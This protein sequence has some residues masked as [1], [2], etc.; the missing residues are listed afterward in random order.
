V[1]SRVAALI[2]AARQ[3]PRRRL[4][5][6]V[7]VA[8]IL[9]AIVVWVPLP[10]AVQMR[11]WAGSA[12][13]W[14]PL[15]FLAAHIVVTVFPFP[16]TAFTLAAGL[17][18]GSVLG[19]G[20]AV[21][22]STLS[23]VIALLL[24]RAVGWQ[25]NRLVSHPA[26]DTLDARLQRRGWPAIVSLRLIPAVPFAVVNYAAGASAVRLLPYTVGTFVGLLPGTLAVVVFGDALTGHVNPLLFGFSALTAGVGIGGMILELRAHRRAARRQCDDAGS[27]GLAVSAAKIAA[28]DAAPAAERLRSRALT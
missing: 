11:D 19:A 8:V 28:N 27:G 3:V 14:L 4:A 18:F 15:V 5:A 16:R 6:I 25:L 20:L 9:I 7:T 2:A 23:A 13:P 12:G 17:M 10:S 21:L 26:V 22:A 1:K 24:V